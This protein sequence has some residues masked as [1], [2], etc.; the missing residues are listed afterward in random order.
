MRLGNFTAWLAEQ[1][2]ELGVEMY[3]GQGGVEVL[4]NDADEA[5]RVET[6]SRT[7]GKRRSHGGALWTGGRCGDQ[8]RGRGE[9]RRAKG[10]V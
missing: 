9:G 7:K 8:R 3:T 2:E 4:Y 10:L 1:A 5:S 6:E